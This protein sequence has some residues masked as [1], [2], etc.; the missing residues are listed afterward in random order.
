MKAVESPLSSTSTLRNC[1]MKASLDCQPSS[2]LRIDESLSPV[3]LDSVVVTDR[4][5]KGEKYINASPVNSPECLEDD[6]V[7]YLALLMCLLCSSYN[8]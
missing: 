4:D 3:S 2:I 5:T 6:Q 7:I 1:S 8:L